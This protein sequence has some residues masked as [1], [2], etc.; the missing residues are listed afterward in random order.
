MFF[1]SGFGRPR[2]IRPGSLVRHASVCHPL[3]SVIPEYVLSGSSGA[4]FICLNSL[5]Q[6]HTVMLLV[7]QTK[8]LITAC[9]VCISIVCYPLVMGLSCQDLQGEVYFVLKT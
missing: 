5:F 2:H 3:E 7:A 4:I 8:F 6:F 1:L 9:P